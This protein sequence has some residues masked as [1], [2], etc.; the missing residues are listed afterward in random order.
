MAFKNLMVM[1]I[2]SLD[3]TTLAS[4]MFIVSLFFGVRKGLLVLYLE[5]MA[6]RRRLAGDTV[7]PRPVKEGVGS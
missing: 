3:K 2:I 5:R 6:Q 7:D 4:G 1:F